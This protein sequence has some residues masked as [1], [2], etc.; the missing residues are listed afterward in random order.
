MLRPLLIVSMLLFAA[1][2][3]AADAGDSAKE[4]TA[5]FKVNDEEND[6]VD[7]YYFLL[8][9]GKG[10]PVK[11][12]IVNGVNVLGGSVIS[13]SMPINVTKQIKQGLNEL[14]VD[15]VSHETEGLVAI[16]EKRV[17]GPKKFEIA[18]L[19]LKPKESQGK[20]VHKEL[21]FNIDPAPVVP[22]KI[23]LSKEDERE[24]LNIVEQYYGALKSKNASKLRSLYAPALRRED[25]VCP[26]GAQFFNKVLNKEIAL[27][28]RSDIKMDE[29][30]I[31][32]VML[33]QEEDKIKALR[34]DRKPMMM[35]NEIDLQVEPI[36]SEIKEE[37]K[38][39]SGKGKSDDED[40]VVGNEEDMKKFEAEQ[41]LRAKRI[42]AGQGAQV[43][44]EEAEKAAKK[45]SEK[46]A[47]AGKELAAVKQR[48]VTTK[49]LFRKIDGQW[50]IALPQGV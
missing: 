6:G 1:P 31:N 10:M 20:Q 13:L 16:M 25:K 40:V 42:A 21:A 29:F 32:D 33:E 18:R 38:S 41:A 30:N 37:K 36:Y 3:L 46:K 39:K 22:L 19:I 11:Q 5:S 8:V 35:S 24:I 12:I 17:P 47:K 4:S 49:L 28:R 44:K 23:D 43:A 45:E 15:Y 26:E 7:E 9:E 14:K 34:K 50:R 48:L 27:L 2:A